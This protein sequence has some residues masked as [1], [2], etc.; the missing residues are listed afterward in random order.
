MRC[1]R[2]GNNNSRSNCARHMR[3]SKAGKA[4]CNARAEVRL[5]DQV[6]VRGYRVEQK[7]C[8]QCGSLLA[9]TNIAGTCKYTGDGE[10]EEEHASF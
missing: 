1:E 3:P 8:P 7:H 2:C 9:E 6:R 10:E 4:A 5:E